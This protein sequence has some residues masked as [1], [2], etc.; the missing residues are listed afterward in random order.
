MLMTCIIYSDIFK[1]CL[2][3]NFE[4]EITGFNNQVI[5]I[6]CSTKVAILCIK[7]TLDMLKEIQAYTI[8]GIMTKVCS[9]QTPY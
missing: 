5:I 4:L 2:Q 1:V 3:S 7:Q 6:K 8:P 9:E